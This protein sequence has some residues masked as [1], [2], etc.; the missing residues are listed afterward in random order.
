VG[1]EPYADAATRAGATVFASSPHVRQ[2]KEYFL[3]MEGERKSAV[4]LEIVTPQAETRTVPLIRGETWPDGVTA[5]TLVPEV[6]E[7]VAFK[8]L[9]AGRVAY[10]ALNSFADDAIYKEFSQGTRTNLFVGSVLIGSMLG[11][12][13]LYSGKVAI[14]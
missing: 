13:F 10:I 9:D 7:D 2:D 12:M 8:W 3:A 4:T 5:L 14:Q 1:G 6:N 11:M